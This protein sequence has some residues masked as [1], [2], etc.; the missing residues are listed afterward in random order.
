MNIGQ[1][2]HFTQSL[3]SYLLLLVNILSSVSV[4]DVLETVVGLLVTGR[5]GVLYTH[6]RNSE[7][8]T[9][10]STLSELILKSPII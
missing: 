4:A 9:C 6:S 7:L 8:S 5:C 1:D 10:L 2:S 3:V